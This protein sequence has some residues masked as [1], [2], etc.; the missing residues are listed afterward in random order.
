MN[1]TFFKAVAI[2]SVGLFAWPALVLGGDLTLTSDG[3]VPGKPFE[4]LQQQINALQ[5]QIDE[6]EAGT[7]KLYENKKDL[8]LPD[9]EPNTP[10][11][12]VT[13][14]LAAGV[15]LTTVTIGAVYWGS[16]EGYYDAA[17]PGWLDCW[18]E[19]SEGTQITGHHFGGN[20]IGMQTHSITMS[21]VLESDTTAKVMCSNESLWF[22][23]VNNM[24]I[25]NAIW[26]AMEVDEFY[27][28]VSTE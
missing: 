26:T 11:A 25:S 13:I 12:V 5:Q 27:N 14:D 1:I 15:Y 19:D 2:I 4:F 22:T 3:K 8:A 9:L 24:G 6:F 18:F 23:P 16:P 28:Q 10:T 17:R 20:V 7:V 21:L